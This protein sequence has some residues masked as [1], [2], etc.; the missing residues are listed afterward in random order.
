MSTLTTLNELL[1]HRILILDG[2][3]GTM[4]QRHRL[5][6]EDF[7]GARFAAHSHDL[8]G[9]N[10]LLV[11]TQPAVIAGIH[12]E[13]LDAGADIIETN[14]FNSNAI[15]QADYALESLV[16]ELNL[17]AARLA[18]AL[19]NVTDCL[20]IPRVV[21]ADLATTNTEAPRLLSLSVA[22]KW[23]SGRSVEVST[24]RLAQSAG[25]TP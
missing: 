7:R 20:S 16:Y 11:L 9:N 15:S 6:E 4:I 1:T 17:E 23:G 19:A 2:A 14:T 10:D 24:L 25:T 13:Y 22:V 21:P 8:K 18:R 5:T 3:M 12:R